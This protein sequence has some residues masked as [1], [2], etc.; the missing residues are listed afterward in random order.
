MSDARTR[1]STVEVSA[2]PQTAFRAF[3]DELDLWWVRGPVNAYDS[4]R[5]VE[6]RCEPGVGGRI[7]EVY[8]GDAL[9][10]ARITA[11]QPGE[12]VAWK[13]S[14][15]DV[16]IDVRFE[17]TDAGTLVRLEATVTESGEDRGGSSF[18]AVTPAWFGAWMRRRDTAPREPHE[19]ARLGLTL[20]YARPAA[21][22]RWLVEAFGFESPSALPEGDD[23]LTDEEYGFPWIELYAGNASVVIE[24]LAVPADLRQVTHVPWV[25]VDDLEGHLARAREHG[26]EIAQE[27]ERTGFTSYVALD[28]EG[29]R[30]RFAQARPT[31]R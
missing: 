30:W 24:P 14:L 3:T 17:P 2:D 29:R 21:A 5:L 9:E 1:E 12:R 20:G 8:E 23:P 11:W 19:L 31:Q 4:G 28:L 22:A 10:L 27:I 15:D 7:L 26:A 25:F 6:M 16:S 18:V 13:S